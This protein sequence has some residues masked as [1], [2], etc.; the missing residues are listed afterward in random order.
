MGKKKKKRPEKCK[1]LYNL[2]VGRAGQ[3]TGRKKKKKA[4]PD[5]N[6]L[7]YEN[8]DVPAVEETA[9]AGEPA[10]GGEDRETTEDQENVDKSAQKSTKKKKKVNNRNRFKPN[11]EILRDRSGAVVEEGEAVFRGF[12]VRQKDWKRLKK[13]EKDLKSQG[14]K[15]KELDEALKKERRIAEKALAR[16]KKLVCFK[17]RQPGHMLAD[18]PLAGKDDQARPSS[19]ICFKC[20]SLEHTSK[21]CKSKR[22]R[23]DAY[24]FASCFIC[25]QEGHIAK[26]CPDNPRGLYPKGGGCV[27]CGSVEHLKRD[28]QR[29]VE[30][31]LRAGV[32]VGTISDNL[33]DEP[34]HNLP[35]INK[36]KNKIQARVPKVV[37]F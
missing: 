1:D 22:T 19:G 18:C 20:G 2:K 10:E 17:C 30:K 6:K 35:F 36:K 27:F 3:G 11:K 24:N 15:S 12:R 13:L 4:K 28:C 14:V 8:D 21:E 5:P 7:P 29:K 9:A 25:K 37:A 34:A 26:S 31:D 32:V 33:E 23:E 16:S